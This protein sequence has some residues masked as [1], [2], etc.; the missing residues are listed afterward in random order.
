M[1]FQRTSTP[2]PIVQQGTNTRET[3]LE[4]DVLDDM[5]DQRR[6]CIFRDDIDTSLLAAPVMTR[7]ER[8][9]I[10]YQFEIQ[11]VPEDTEVYRST[12]SYGLRC[13]IADIT[14]RGYSQLPNPYHDVDYNVRRVVI[15]ER[16]SIQSIV[17]YIFLQKIGGGVNV[18]YLMTIQYG[19]VWKRNVLQ[20]LRNRQI[21]PALPQID[22]DTLETDRQ[23]L[24][25]RM[26]GFSLEPD[27][28][29]Y[30]R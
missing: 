18:G 23:D 9:Q 8:G 27:N 20:V 28:L 21:R 15:E 16:P 14:E 13:L 1:E 22:E 17:V 29:S 19:S 25:L 4:A 11:D 7:I 30:R 12:H 10:A 3:I 24:E 26:M 6:P 5:Y 2:R